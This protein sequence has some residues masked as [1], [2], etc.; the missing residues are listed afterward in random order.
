VASVLAGVLVLGAVGW[1][2]GVFAPDHPTP[3]REAAAQP[4]GVPPAVAAPN[5]AYS[6]MAVQDDGVTPVAYD[7]CRPVHYVVRA[8]GEPAGGRQMITEAFLRLSQ[9]TGL[10]FV[11]DGETTESPSADREPFQ[12][13][14]YG[15]RWAPV[16][17]A[18]SDQGEV[19]DLGGDVA[20]LGGSQPVQPLMGPAV[21]VT[22]Q[23]VLDGPLFSEAMALPGGGPVAR[24]VVLHELAHVVGLGHV[25]DAD[26]LM[27]PYASRTDLGDGDLTGL[28]LL[29]QGV[30]VPEL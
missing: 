1:F 27:F 11:A 9:A 24:A 26:Q 28:A 4:I 25:E 10:Q 21:Y 12:P 30:C 17:I 5:P 23:I 15:D 29:G 22:G 3:G 7:P 6:F 16:L 13:D 8:E 18:W 14:R 20:G 2:T 19:S